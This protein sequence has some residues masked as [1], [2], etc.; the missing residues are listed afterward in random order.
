[1]S[2]DVMSGGKVSSEKNERKSVVCMVGCTC[3]LLFIC[4]FVRSF[5]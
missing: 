1:M 3:T 4:P 5:L 2:D